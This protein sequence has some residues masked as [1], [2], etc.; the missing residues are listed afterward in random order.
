VVLTGLGVT[1][2][3]YALLDIQSDILSRPELSSDARMLS[4]LTGIPTVI[5][6]I[7]WI[8]VG[9]VACWFVGKKLLDRA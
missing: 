5:W 6:G 2:A 8:G 9:L 3:M 1:S 4:E 7:L